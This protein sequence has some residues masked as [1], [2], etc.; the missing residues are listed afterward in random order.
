M[1]SR[2]TNDTVAELLTA[3]RAAEPA[4][5][6]TAFRQLVDA[7]WVHGYLTDLALP[8]VPSL[9]DALGELDDDRRGRLVV[10]LGL[11]AEAEYPALDG[12]VSGAVRAGLTTYLDLLRTT[13]Y[14]RPLSL[15]LLYLVSHFPADRD[16]V[17]AAAAGLDLSE[18]DQSRL[19][20]LLST[21]DAASPAIGRVWPAP[22]VWTL[23]E[24]ERAFDRNWIGALT[25]EQV[26]ANWEN[27][28][29][30]VYGFSGAQAY[31]AVRHGD[32]APIEELPAGPVP[33]ATPVGADTGIFTP[34]A[35]VLRC[36]ACDSRL[37]FQPGRVRCGECAT[38]YPVANGVLNL[39]GGVSEDA[40]A[41]DDVTADLLSK[42][43]EM[44]SMGLYY[45]S[46]LRPA[47]LQIAG[48]NWGG[49]VT[50]ADEHRYIGSH[51]EPVEGPVLDLAAGA[52]SW[53]EVIARTVGTERL[54]ALDMGLPML[55]VLRA[56][57]PE[58][59]AVQASA[60]DLPFA[61]ASLGAVICWNALQ[62][63]PDDAATAIAEVGRCLKPGGT[64]TMMT[65]VWDEDPITRHFQA[66]HYFPSRPEGMLLFEV[67]EITKRMAD[68]GMTVR[69]DSGPVSFL[70][71][72]AERDS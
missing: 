61:D 2:P 59:P 27:D 63:F 14:P 4:Q 6:D 1:D 18:Q 19:E 55:S 41:A 31:W 13:A 66:S 64:F 53:T 48:A 11:L 24:E 70:F 46:V 16:R 37:D 72:T 10:L 38:T 26:V 34:H 25:P 36:P 8:A 17:L 43:A 35:S 58:V 7:L 50:L 45:E 44:P 39:T 47:Y 22:V 62:A 32:V 20:R 49:E 33:D 40:E 21:L 67:D 30:T 15:A 57:L 52:G 9:I 42:L 71:L 69:A 54:I 65:F 28:T 56:R 5:R 68:A 12:P 29:R 23:T 3:Y 60:L 51:I